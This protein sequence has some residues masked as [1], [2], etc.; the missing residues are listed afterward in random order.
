MLAA[1]GSALGRFVCSLVLRAVCLSVCLF[2]CLFVCADRHRS[3][4]FSAAPMAPP[5]G[6]RCGILNCGSAGSALGG[7]AEKMKNQ[8]LVHCG[9]QKAYHTVR[10][11]VRPAHSLLRLSV[12]LSRLSV[13]LSRLSVPL[14]RLSVPLSRLSVPLSRWFEP[15][16][17]SSALAFRVHRLFQRGIAV[18]WYAAWHERPHGPLPHSLSHCGRTDCVSQPA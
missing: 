8:P 11:E 14:S 1:I 9:F 15:L 12:L 17:R 6:R 16:S 10:D 4:S 13:P 3:R 18:R 2:I 7:V 5:N